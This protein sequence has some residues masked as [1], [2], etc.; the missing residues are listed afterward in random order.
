MVAVGDT[1]L[2]GLGRLE[3][4][5][6]A[7]LPDTEG[8]EDVESE[9]DTLRDPSLEKV[10]EWD[11]SPVAEENTEGEGQGE[12][13]TDTVL[14]LDEL[15]VRVPHEGEGMGENVVDRDIAGEAESVGSTD[16]DTEMVGVRED[17]LE[18]VGDTEGDVVSV[19]TLNPPMLCVF[20][21]VV[22][23]LKFR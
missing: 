21:A 15:P 20:S 9:G 4:V 23:V 14:V 17:D 11:S 3:M 6:L 2:V 5:E 18:E 1:E 22:M 10:E 8:V 7:A 13:E 16:D 19:G 12:A